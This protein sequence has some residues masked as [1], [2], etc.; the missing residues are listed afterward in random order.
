MSTNKVVQNLLKEAH[1][2]YKT[3]DLKTSKKFLVDILNIE[4]N[5]YE[6][7]RNH[8]VINKNL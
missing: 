3:K 7:I 5:N 4:K 2:K 8:R 6:T 1:V